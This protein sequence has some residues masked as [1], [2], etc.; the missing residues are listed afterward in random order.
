RCR[1]GLRPAHGPTQPKTQVQL[2]FAEDHRAGRTAGEDRASIVGA[3]GRFPD[4]GAPQGFAEVARAAAAEVD[5]V[6]LAYRL[7]MGGIVGGV[8][9]PDRD[10]LDLGA[11]APEVL[12]AQRREALERLLALRKG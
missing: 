10:R 7:G 11:E 9:V 5:D 8:A 6:G 4:D 12:L 2:A 1:Q 3:A